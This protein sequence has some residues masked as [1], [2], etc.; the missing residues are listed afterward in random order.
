MKKEILCDQCER[1]AVI[2]SWNGWHLCTEHY[3]KKTKEV[4]GHQKT[5]GHIPGQRQSHS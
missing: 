3:K 4:N 1:Y 2:R 5:L